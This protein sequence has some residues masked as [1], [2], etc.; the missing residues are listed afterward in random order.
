MPPSQTGEEKQRE[1][2]ENSKVTQNLGALS[3]IDS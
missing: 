1:N 3:K 2:L